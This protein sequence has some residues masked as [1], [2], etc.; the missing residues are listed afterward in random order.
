M[1]VAL[2]QVGKR[3]PFL[4]PLSRTGVTTAPAAGRRRECSSCSSLNWRDPPTQRQKRCCCHH[5]HSPAHGLQPQTGGA[6]PR[7]IGHTLRGADQQ[8]A[9][10]V[11]REGRPVRL[12]LSEGQSDFTGAD[13]LLRDLPEA[14]VLIG[15]KG[16][17]ATRFAPCCW[18]KASL[19]ASVQREP[20][21]EGPSQQEALQDAP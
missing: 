12:H 4:A 11:R 16:T 14:S 3:P 17:T 15:E 5:R 2:L 21:Q 13:L 6:A 8:A 20:Q 1:P 9:C 10:G 7:L 18:S 19:P